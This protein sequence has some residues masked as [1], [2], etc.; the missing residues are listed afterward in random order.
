MARKPDQQWAGMEIGDEFR[1][2]YNRKQLY[3]FSSMRGRWLKKGRYFRVTTVERPGGFDIEVRRVATSEE[4]FCGKLKPTTGPRYPWATTPPGEAFSE[5]FSAEKLA[6]LR[7]GAA[8]QYQIYLRRFT[9]S[10][11]DDRIV[12]R[13]VL[14][15]LHEY[16]W[17][18]TPVGGYFLVPYSEST[19]GRVMG[20]A[21]HWKNHNVVF[22]VIRDR[23]GWAVVRRS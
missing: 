5:D 11:Q 8:R 4:A 15:H 20:M 23:T 10:V 13:R 7:S 14:D 18:R 6:S 17:D 3:A 2:P 21:R 9:V 1:V 16:P 22:E 19:R 12:V